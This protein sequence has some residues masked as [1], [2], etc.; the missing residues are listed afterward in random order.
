MIFA[1]A[2]TLGCAAKNYDVASP[3][4]RLKAE[5]GVDATGIKWCIVADGDTV[6]QPSEIALNAPDGA[7]TGTKVLS[8]KRSSV[9]TSFATPLYRKQAVADRYN[10]L[11]LR[12]RGG[13]SL[14]LRAYDD[15]AAYRLLLD[16]PGIVEI[17]SET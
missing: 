16:R 5:V 10:E 7:I 2:V 8:A 1:L 14:Q 3:D 4:G 12:L 15:A 11:T 9:D 6:M 17:A 13:C